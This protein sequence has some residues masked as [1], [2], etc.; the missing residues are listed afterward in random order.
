MPKRK[1]KVAVLKAFRET[2]LNPTYL[3]VWANLIE[4]RPAGVEPEVLKKCA[5]D[6]LELIFAVAADWEYIERKEKPQDGYAQRHADAAMGV[7]HSL[8]TSALNVSSGLDGRYRTC[9]GN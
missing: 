3:R 1:T 6:A 9:E 5:E 8:L 4:G 7:V 2:E